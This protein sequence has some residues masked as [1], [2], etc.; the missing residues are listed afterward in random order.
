[1][2]RSQP[3]ILEGT[4]EATKVCEQTDS[5]EKKDIPSLK[6]F[7]KE[8]FHVIV[9][10]LEEYEWNQKSQFDGSVYVNKNIITGMISPRR[11]STKMERL[12]QL[13]PLAFLSAS[14]Q[15]FA[16]KIFFLSY[17]TATS[18]NEFTFFSPVIHTLIIFRISY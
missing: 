4:L 16:Y 14:S 5:N 7:L 8:H 18:I 6:Y 17:N 2:G 3:P 13:H 11:P 12:I 15:N 1:M 10:G 9:G